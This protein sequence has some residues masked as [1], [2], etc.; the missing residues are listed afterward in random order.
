[1]PE[2]PEPRV[3]QVLIENLQQRLGEAIADVSPAND[4]MTFAEFATFLAMVAQQLTLQVEKDCGTS[5]ALFVQ[6]EIIRII[7]EV[8]LGGGGKS[9][10]TPPDGAVIH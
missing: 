9:T 7:Y 4:P 5:D 10:E 6:D 2:N 1:M 3:R 8:P